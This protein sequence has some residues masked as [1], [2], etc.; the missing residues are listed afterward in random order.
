MYIMPDWLNSIDE[1]K[2]FIDL[3][4]IYEQE[5]L[6]IFQ[7][8]APIKINFQSTW[9]KIHELHLR[10]CSEVENLIKLITK[11]IYPNRD[12]D[13]EHRETKSKELKILESLPWKDKEKIK[14]QLYRYAD[15]PFYL[16]ILNKELWICDKKIEFSRI[17]ETRPENEIVF[18]QPLEKNNETK[19]IPEWWENYNNLKHDKVD[20]YV[21]C[22]LRDLINSLWAYYMLLNYFSMNI[23]NPIYD[24]I[25]IKSKIFRPTIWRITYPKEI[26]NYL[27]LFREDKPTSFFKAVYYNGKE[28]IPWYYDENLMKQLKPKIQKADNEYV[29]SDIISRGN[30][31]L[32]NENFLFYNLIEQHNVAR[33]WVDGQLKESLWTLKLV[34]RFNIPKNNTNI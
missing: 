26:R 3:F 15:M 10:V 1:K 31:R 20:N 6:T 5:L 34:K 29:L 2:V 17:I 18:I 14:R 30:K 8:V 24:D 7:Y 12:F 16:D 9:N 33:Y 27:S 11:K 19:F 21:K 32:K 28:I 22:S 13:Y 23:K 25:E 4:D